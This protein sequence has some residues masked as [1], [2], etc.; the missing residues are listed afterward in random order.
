MVTTK[1]FARRAVL[2][3]LLAGGL[4]ALGVE[5]SATGAGDA[6][7]AYREPPRA[8]MVINPQPLPPEHTIRVINP[9]P[10][11]PESGAVA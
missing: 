10:P 8:L 5:A 3:A 1:R 2:A 7:K 4:A 9:E 6:G 11:V